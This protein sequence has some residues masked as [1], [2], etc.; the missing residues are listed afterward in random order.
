MCAAAVLLASFGA[1][2]SINGLWATP[3][4]R[5][6]SL[7]G[8]KLALGLPY[9]NTTITRKVDM[10]ASTTLASKGPA[11]TQPQRALAAS[12]KSLVEEVFRGRL[13]HTTPRLVMAA[14]A[15]QFD[16]YTSVPAPPEPPEPPAPAAA[17]AAT[18]PAASLKGLKAL[19]EAEASRSAKWAAQA[20]AAAKA[21]EQADVVAV[22]ASLNGPMIITQSQYEGLERALDQALARL[23][24]SQALAARVNELDPSFFVVRAD[25]KKFCGTAQIDR[26]CTLLSP[27]DVARIRSD[28]AAQVK[29]ADKE[30]RQLQVKL[31]RARLT[32]G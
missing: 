28:V 9:G 4:A 18:L 25:G 17:L 13:V 3:D 7:D 26:E 8:L 19:A 5:A 23:E 6:S 27:T 12:N 2:G 24:V 21:A 30:V 16:A 11:A 32:D 15:P 1:A 20:A 10:G 22:Q 31:S 14:A 29:L